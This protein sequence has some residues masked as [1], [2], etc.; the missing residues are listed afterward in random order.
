MADGADAFGGALQ[1]SEVSVG[2]SSDIDERLATLVHLQQLQQKQEVVQR[3]ESEKAANADA[4][5]RRGLE[6][7]V[8]DHLNTCIALASCSSLDPDISSSSNSNL[9]S[10]PSSYNTLHDAPENTHHSLHDE[11]H[12]L[13]AYAAAE[14]HDDILDQFDTSQAHESDIPV[15]Q[16]SESPCCGVR[17]RI[18]EQE[19]GDY[20]HANTDQLV[21]EQ[22]EAGDSLVDNHTSAQERPRSS[23]LSIWAA[24]RAQEMITTMERQ[25]REAELLA[26]AGLHTVSTL[27]AS[28]L[29]E[30][31]RTGDS[32]ISGEERQRGRPSSMVQM[33]RELE[34]ERR[35][36]RVRRDFEERTSAPTA[37]SHT[38][39]NADT[40]ESSTNAHMEDEVGQSAFT[41][42]RAAD[43]QVN[44][45]TEHTLQSHNEDDTDWE[46]NGME[47][48]SMHE[49]SE[50]PERDSV[51][52]QEGEREHVRQIV[53]RLTTDNGVQ[54]MPSDGPTQSRSAWLDENER[55][56]VR[57]LA[58]EWVR[59]TNEQRSVMQER[60]GRQ[61]LQRVNRPEHTRERG[62]AA[63]A[64]SLNEDAVQGLSRRERRFLNRQVIL[65]MLMRV[66]NERQRELQLLVEH[67]A[68]SD[69][70]HR[71]R[72]QS[73]LRGRFLR[74]GGPANEEER[75]PSS[76]AGELGQ[77]RQRRAVSDLREGFRF[78]L[79]SIL[80][81]QVN[82]R[83][84]EPTNTRGASQRRRRRRSEDQPVV[85]PLAGE[86]P[87]R[88]W[89]PS[90]NVSRGRQGNPAPRR[91]TE[92]QN[93][94][95]STEYNMEL[96]E[97][98]GRRS[99]TNVLA[100][101]FRDRLDRLIRS[102]LQTQGRS[103]VTWDMPRT[104]A[105]QQQQQQQRRQLRPR[106]QMQWQQQVPSPQNVIPPPPPPPPQPLWQQE[107]Q[108]GLWQRPP[109]SLHRPSHTE[110]EG[111]ADL[112]TDVSK[113]Q[114]GMAD[115]HR[116]METCLE[117]QLDLQRSLRQELA[118][119][120]QQMYEGK[121]IPEEA[122]D[123]SKWVSVKRGIC[124]VCCDR[125][126]D[127]LLYR[128]GHM[129]TCLN[130]ASE[131]IRKS[132]K[133]PMCRAPIKEV[134]RAFTVA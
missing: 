63:R 15:F 58:R 100:S 74:T 70:A 12:D 125:N 23:I 20:E 10:R 111:I 86:S 55:E 69:F 13:D 133:C 33:W 78:R 101:D 77:L 38:S 41:G 94:E 48:S 79:E 96:Q 34:E 89:A 128:C 59:V 108:Q 37:L 87:R 106:Q 64:E 88:R 24:Q 109:L 61:R 65:D 102:F 6:E 28:F 7:L 90:E 5:F 18:L 52:T 27:D 116:M 57:E 84:T 43:S 105:P 29:R 131:L 117:M 62:I 91:V 97:L 36:E 127:S 75:V 110:G 3:M 121:V 72:L 92:F 82:N 11:N 134:V 126:I 93:M 112:R 35:T 99:V 132:G 130:C 103:P 83:D 39:G 113:L 118:G 54:A 9:M 2:S 40:S 56:R 51:H 53:Q 66:E 76:A 50:V 73:F 129:C 67:R 32:S 119:A 81:T 30:S 124:C 123:G 85:Q 95:E 68:V 45:D 114:H 80:R 71:H 120:L 4:G 104:E 17:R 98:L 31:L 22:R 42:V 44:E 8:R 122:I 25:A 115:L 19:Q 1:S 49:N 47:R 60:G 46:G 16:M 21:Q 107:L 26:L 14:S